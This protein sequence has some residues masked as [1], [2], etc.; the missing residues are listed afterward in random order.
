MTRGLTPVDRPD[1]LWR[2][3]VVAATAGL[4]FWALSVPASAQSI[5]GEWI[6]VE[7]QIVQVSKSG[8]EYLGHYRTGPDNG[9][10]ALQVRPSGTGGYQGQSYVY[11][12]GPRVSHVSVRIGGGGLELTSCIGPDHRRP[13]CR[14][15]TW[16][17]QLRR[18]PQLA[19][20]IRDEIRKP[21][22]RPA[23]RQPDM[24]LQRTP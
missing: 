7:D 5:S 19:P 20:A 3:G 21:M 6:D 4:A 23:I 16:R 24:R 11:D 17:R 14:T 18:P 10:L 12:D 15:E 8:T 13:R 2:P 9:K 22:P 1:T